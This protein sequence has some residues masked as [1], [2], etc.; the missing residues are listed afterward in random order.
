[1]VAGAKKCPLLAVP[2]G[3]GEHAVKIFQAVRPM[4]G[5]GCK[6]HRRVGIVQ[7]H[8]ARRGEF[9][10][11]LTKIID[12]SVKDRAKAAIR[13]QHWLRPASDINDGKTPVAK[14]YRTLPPLPIP[15][16]T[17]PGHSVSHGLDNLAGA[18]FKRLPIQAA[19]T[20]YAAHVLSFTRAALNA[21]SALMK[22]SARRAALAAGS[23]RFL[24]RVMPLA[25]MRKASAGFCASW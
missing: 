13:A 16:R 20:G 8:C 7:K 18:R 21:A 14:A 5:I 2:Y 22:T 17:A 4:G 15:I 3:K 1:M 11:E 6:Q 12:L 9:L 10:P 25:A 24:A 19:E 23:K